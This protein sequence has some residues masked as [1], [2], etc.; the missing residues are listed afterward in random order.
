VGVSGGQGWSTLSDGATQ[1]LGLAAADVSAP[2]EPGTLLG[3]R[4]QLDARLGVGGSGAVYAARD[5]LRGEDVA[6]KVLH[7][8]FQRDQPRVER[9]RAEVRAARRIAHHN[10][11][12]VHDLGELE[13]VAFVAMELLSGQTLRQRLGRHIALVGGAEISITHEPACVQP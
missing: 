1:A 5:L 12:R 4:F 11:C 3:R 2:L 10:V 7:G 6:F 8:T 13:G 9:L